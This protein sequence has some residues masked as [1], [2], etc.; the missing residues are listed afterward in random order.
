MTCKVLAVLASCKVQPNELC[1]LAH[2]VRCHVL[3]ACSSKVM[4][5]A[6]LCTQTLLEET[7]DQPVAGNQLV[8]VLR[9]LQGMI[10]R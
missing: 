1:S 6:C 4:C 9:Q 5:S 8:A 7:A 2:W 3:R 10:K